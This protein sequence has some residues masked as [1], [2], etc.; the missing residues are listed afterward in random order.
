MR[1]AV[2]PAAV[3]GNGFQRNSGPDGAPAPRPHG[4]PPAIP[5]ATQKTE[6]RA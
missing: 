2:L 4:S 3:T 1:F 6:S 5:M